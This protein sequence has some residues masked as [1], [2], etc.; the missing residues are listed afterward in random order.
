MPKNKIA[1]FSAEIGISSNLPTYSGG[2]GVLAGDHIKSAADLGIDM[3]AI[4]IL[5]KEG[6]FKQII[7]QEGKQKEVYPKFTP[8]P[9]LTQLNHM[10]SIKLN[11]KTIY[12]KAFVYVHKS[13][14]GNNIPIYFLD[15]DITENDNDIR[16]ITLRLYSGD[17]KHRILQEAVLGYGGMKLL[18]ILGE[19]KIV[20]YHMNEGHCSF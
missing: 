17:N 3:V 12:I 16:Q 11:R 14:N 19:D 18:D 20:K 6:Y 2:L 8:E 9:L 15:T 5:Y 13:I 7:D 10:L 1:Y 4:S